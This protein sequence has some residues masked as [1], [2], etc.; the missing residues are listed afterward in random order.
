MMDSISIGKTVRAWVGLGA[1]LG[2]A[3]DTLEH[4]IQKLAS[5]PHTSLSAVSSF[6]KT[7]PVDAYGPD[8][9]NA[10]ACCLT[11]LPAIEMLKAMQSIEKEFGRERPYYH[12]PRT[13]DLDLLLYGD[14]KMQTAFLTLP[15]PA[16]HLR[17]FVLEPLYELDQTLLIPEHGDVK[18]LLDALPEQKIERL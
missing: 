11:N 3:K 12:A 15:H 14:L 6:Y 5:L 7:A 9:I 1:N 18:D 8:Y 2:N 4:A 16:M 17:R 13:L 10:V